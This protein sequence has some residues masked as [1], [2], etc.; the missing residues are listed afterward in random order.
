MNGDA[1]SSG[2]STS[3]NDSLTANT[4]AEVNRL[5]L[6][7]W[8]QLAHAESSA[9]FYHSWLTLQCHQIIHCKRG[10][11]VLG[12]VD[13][14][15]FAPVAYWPEGQGGSEPLAALAEQALTARKGM[16]LK[17]ELPGV[18]GQHAARHGIAFPIQ[19]DE[20]L[21]GVVAVE[22][23]PRAQAELQANMRQLQWASG[24]LEAY[25]R[26]QQAKGD[27]AMRERL[28]SALDLI[29]SSLEQEHFAVAAKNFVTELATQLACERV[30][31]GFVHRGHA[32]VEAVS[33]SAQF[34]KQMNLIR[35][36]ASAMDEAM[37]QL[38]TIQYPPPEDSETFVTRNHAA[39]AAQHGTT[40]VLT[41]PLFRQG[42]VYGVLCLERSDETTP[43]DAAT[44]E[45]CRSVAA[46]VGPVLEEKRSNDRWLFEK[47]FQSLHTQ[48]T[49][50]VGPEYFLRKLVLSGL[51]VLV[52]F[53]SLVT[54]QYNI[55]ADTVLEGSVQ[56]VIAAPFEGYVAEARVRAGDV[57]A[58]DDVLATLDDR[59]LKLERLKWSSQL[60]QL[61]KQYDGAMA[62]RDRAQINII[63]AQIGQAD[64]QLALINEQLSRTL[65]TAPFSGVI[66]SGDL[67]Q[68]L[69][70]SVRR[71]DVL[72]EIAPLDTYRVILKVNEHDINDLAV[73]QR[74][75]LVLSAMPDTVFPLTVQ[76]ITPVSTA[77]EGENYFR[78]EAAL[79]GNSEALQRGMLSLRPGMEGVGK[80]VVDERRLIWIWTHNMVNRIR[81]W[82]WRWMP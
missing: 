13:T 58:K 41:I 67:N 60:A 17:Y 40:T 38:A 46:V 59:D 6:D 24:W 20:H 77:E 16:V 74:G 35:A 14:G 3:S 45:L 44:V 71:G 69:G 54:G 56:R 29:A 28:V 32:R 22:L 31:I 36:I 61:H 8:Q 55:K 49:R 11:L 4:T 64:A 18:D 50:L 39:L 5:E 66:I 63:S 53:F 76:R 73:K 27:S 1:I 81:L 2:A 51:L 75:E 25:L 70:A 33:H 78:V 19:I 68:S 7:Q 21:Y 57:V 34:G 62:K 72:F 52:V 42:R 12:T 43:F 65:I 26:K 47:V 48:F 82:L 15:P 23:E 37:D 80:V 9:S 10:V 30:S 79:S